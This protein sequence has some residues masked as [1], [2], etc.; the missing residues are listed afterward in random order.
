LQVFFL[1]FFMVLLFIPICGV[2]AV[3]RM[4]LWKDKFDALYDT[5]DYKA[6]WVNRLVPVIFMFKR[7]GLAYMC[8]VADSELTLILLQCV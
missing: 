1:V 6:S 3:K 4:E 5:I 2:S 8:L 7:I